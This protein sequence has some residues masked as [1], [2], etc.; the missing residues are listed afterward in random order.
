MEKEK[1]HTTWY[2]PFTEMD[3]IQRAVNFVLSHAVTGICTAGDITLLP[4]V[5]KA[6]EDFARMSPQDIGKL[7]ESGRSYQPLFV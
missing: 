5:L 4:K 3:E 7:I 2:E 6:C 1:T